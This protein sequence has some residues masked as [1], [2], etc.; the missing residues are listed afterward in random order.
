MADTPRT[1]LQ[2]RPMRIVRKLRVRVDDG[3]DAGATCAPDDGATRSRSAP[4]SDNALVLADPAVSR[5]HLELA[6]HARR[7]CRSSISAAATARGSAACASSARSSRRARGCG[8]ATRR[9]SSTTPARTVAPPPGEVAALGG[10]RRR[11][12]GDP[13]G[14]AA[15]P[16]ARARRLVGADPGRDRHRQ[17]GRRARDPR[18]EPAP[19]RTSSSSSTAAR[20]RRR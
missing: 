5:Y 11:Q 3:P 13:R 7:R 6:P 12:R 9:S 17:G 10:S 4:P 1:K 14:R 15:R 8:S 2:P 16:Q 18:R 19:R 20:C